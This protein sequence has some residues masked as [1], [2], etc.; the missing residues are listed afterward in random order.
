MEK[1]KEGEE[2]V[3]RMQ[4]QDKH[5]EKERGKEVGKWRKERRKQVSGEKSERRKK[6]IIIKETIF[7]VC[8]SRSCSTSQFQ[9][10]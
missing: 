1:M 6:E 8:R 9:I 3:I 4:E 10:N 7:V 2:S 5:K